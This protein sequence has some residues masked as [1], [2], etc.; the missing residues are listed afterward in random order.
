M[1]AMLRETSALPSFT[2]CDDVLL[3][4][5]RIIGLNSVD[6]RV[7]CF[8]MTPFGCRVTHTSRAVMCISTETRKNV[9]NHRGQFQKSNLASNGHVAHAVDWDHNLLVIAIR[10]DSFSETN[11][12]SNKSTSLQ[13]VA[14]SCTITK[15][16]K[17]T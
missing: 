10:T 6:F 7:E 17:I 15:K 11:C 14:Q 8:I 2:Q 13:H 1:A 4:L 5:G 16:G 9:T 3:C 12:F